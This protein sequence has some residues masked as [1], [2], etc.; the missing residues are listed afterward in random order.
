MTAPADQ[1]PA[2]IVAAA[3]LAL[4]NHYG[5]PNAAYAYWDPARAAVAAVVPLLAA[6]RTPEETL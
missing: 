1:I 5:F 6:L 2:E 3:A 4:A